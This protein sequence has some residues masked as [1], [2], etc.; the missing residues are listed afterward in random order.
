MKI[1]ELESKILTIKNKGYHVG[2]TKDD[3][4][5]LDQL[6]ADIDSHLVATD[7]RW[8]HLHTEI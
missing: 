6:L 1:K 8:H 7:E 4:K 5:E 2:L 3:Y